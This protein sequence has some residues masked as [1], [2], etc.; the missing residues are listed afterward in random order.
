V[1]IVGGEHARQKRV[2]VTGIDAA[3][4]AARLPLHS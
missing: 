3:T 2:R 4:A 1:S